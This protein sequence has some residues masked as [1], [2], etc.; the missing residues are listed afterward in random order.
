MKALGLFRFRLCTLLVLVTLV[1]LGLGVFVHCIEQR[2]RA[3]AEIR[4]LGGTV[5]F[6]KRSND[7]ASPW[8]PDAVKKLLGEESFANVW[9]ISLEGRHVGD[10]NLRSLAVLRELRRLDLSNT[11]V[12]DSGLRNVGKLENLEL[13][14]II[15]S[16][17]TDAGLLHLKNLTQLR[18]LNLI[19]T[20]V[21]GRTIGEIGGGGPLKTL[22][23]AKTPADNEGIR[24]IMPQVNLEVVNLSGTLVDDGG[25]KLLEALPRL[26]NLYVHN[27][28][29]TAAGV[30]GLRQKH[31]SWAIIGPN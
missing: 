26:T 7:D 4:A 29:V 5:L 30:N 3:L 18:E 28:S 13:L 9:R 16:P 8:V 22:H 31:P 2:K 1:S 21:T 12:T 15:N 24:G 20:K 10:E 23:L 27:T 14:E 25:L 6:G 17:I 11:S 19:H